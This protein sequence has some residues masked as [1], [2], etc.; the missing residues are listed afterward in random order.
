[1]AEAELAARLAAFHRLPVIYE[2]DPDWNMGETNLHA[3]FEHILRYG[4]AA[5][6][7]SRGNYRVFSNLN[8]NYQPRFPTVYVA[9]DVMVVQPSRPLGEEVSS[10][11][12][13]RDGPAPLFVAEALSERT[14]E[15][16]DLGE[17]VDLYALIGVA[18][19]L[20]IDPTGRFLPQRLLLKRLRPNRTWQDEQDADG[21]VTS[22]LGFRV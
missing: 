11:L 8:L 17:K 12:I 10:Y 14:A 1:M 16:R 5:H 18:E 9:P 13:D 4:I 20:L 6:L 19:Y 21:G 7:S 3:L 22:A 2:D 15:E